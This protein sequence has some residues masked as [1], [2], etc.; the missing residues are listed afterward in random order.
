MFDLHGRGY[1]RM[2]DGDAQRL[3]LPQGHAWW[4]CVLPLPRYRTAHFG[5]IPPLGTAV[6]SYF[7]HKRGPGYVRGGTVGAVA[8][9]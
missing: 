7:V 6:G 2:S 5:N 8:L 3:S 1:M 4:W 9:R